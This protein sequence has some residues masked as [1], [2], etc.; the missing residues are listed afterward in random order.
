MF[1]ELEV[2]RPRVW[3]KARDGKREMRDVWRWI[4]RCGG[5][6]GIGGEVERS[7]SVEFGGEEDSKIR[8]RMGGVDKGENLSGGRKE[9]IRRE[10][11]SREGRRGGTLGEGGGREGRRDRAHKS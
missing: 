5:G 2:G 8:E 11:S 1:W 7:W 6:E 4:W 9:T 3:E 10:V